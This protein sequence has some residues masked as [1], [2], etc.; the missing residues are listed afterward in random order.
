MARRRGIMAA[1]AAW[2]TLLLLVYYTLPGIRVAVWGVLRSP[3]WLPSGS[4]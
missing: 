3:A 2:M 1:Y 4:A